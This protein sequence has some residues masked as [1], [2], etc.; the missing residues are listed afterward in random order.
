MTVSFSS[1]WAS[2]TTDNAS[3]MLAAFRVFDDPDMS[4]TIASGP[5]IGAAEQQ[6]P[7]ELEDEINFDYEV[8][9]EFQ[10]IRNLE[11][12]T[13]A[14]DFALVIEDITSDPEINEGAC[15][16]FKTSSQHHHCLAH[17]LQLAIRDSLKCPIIQNVCK[18]LQ[19]IVRWFSR[20]NHFYTKLKD[21]TKNAL[22]SP[23][24]TRWNSMFLSLERF[25]KE[26]ADK[27]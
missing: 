24:E 12:E 22:I 3:N 16:L 13:Q 8:G 27:V 17:L 15:Q 20:S 6:G 9:S 5:D 1:Q 26:C 18:K 21:V 19:S 7:T 2:I 11:T 10:D 25:L 23:C 4:P 14:P